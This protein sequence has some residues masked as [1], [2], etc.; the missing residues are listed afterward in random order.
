MNRVPTADGGPSRHHRHH[1]EPAG[2]ND[3]DLP[4]FLRNA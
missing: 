3:D 1:P 2:A 4:E